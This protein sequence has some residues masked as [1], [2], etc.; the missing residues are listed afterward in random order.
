M[1]SNAY[2]AELQVDPTLRRIVILSGTGLLLAGVAAVMT[3][4]VPPAQRVV[5]ALLWAAWCAWSI[6]RLNGRWRTYVALRVSADRRVT[7][8]DR[9]GEWRD[10]TLVPG[11]ILLQDWG[12]IRLRTGGGPAFAEPLRAARQNRRDWRRLQVIWRHIGAPD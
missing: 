9:N 3:L 12:W 8:C 5:A 10:A 2:S 1:A 7:L 4:P 6:W 11:S